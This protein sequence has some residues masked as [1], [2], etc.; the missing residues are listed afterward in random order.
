VFIILWLVSAFSALTIW[1]ASFSPQ[2]SAAHHGIEFGDFKHAYA[3]SVDI[4]GTIY[5]LDGGS[6]EII[7]FDSA[8]NVQL[9]TGGF[10]WTQSTFDAPRD[11]I[12]PNGLDVYVADYGNHRIQRFDRNLNFFSSFPTKDNEVGSRSFGYPRSVAVSNSGALYITDGENNRVLKVDIDGS[13]R[14]FGGIDAASGRLRHPSCVRMSDN[15]LVFVQDGNAIVT[16]DRFGNYL[17]KSNSD[18]FNNLTTFTVVGDTIYALDSCKLIKIH[19]RGTVTAVSGEIC[20]LFGDKPQQIVDL[21]VLK[22]KCY[23]LTEHSIYI[24]DSEVLFK[25]NHQKVNQQ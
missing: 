20:S 3:I 11:I 4:S 6:N 5:V 17:R 2:R 19:E 14:T 9:R 16:F 10:G 13:Q 18:L 12:A 24:I 8:Y 1:Y 23:I 15:E 25:S 22:G 21:A 7:K